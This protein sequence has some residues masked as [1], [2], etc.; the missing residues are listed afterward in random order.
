MSTVI[1]ATRRDLKACHLW[2]RNSLLSRHRGMGGVVLEVILAVLVVL[3]VL[4]V[5]VVL[6]VAL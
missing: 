1:R 5:M 3:V 4:V 2:P 6:F